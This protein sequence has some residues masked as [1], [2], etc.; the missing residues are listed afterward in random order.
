MSGEVDTPDAVVL[1]PAEDI[2]GWVAVHLPTYTAD[3]GES[4][5]DALRGLADALELRGE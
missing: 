3:Q 4:K 5:P 2:D 1:N